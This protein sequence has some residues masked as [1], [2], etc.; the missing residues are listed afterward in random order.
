M[1]ERTLAVETVHGIFGRNSPPQ[2]C[3][4]PPWSQGELHIEGLSIRV[5]P[6]RICSLSRMVLSGIV[7]GAWGGLN[8]RPKALSAFQG[9]K[10]FQI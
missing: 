10:W 4:S 7:M 5:T 3:L 9:R 6:E 2:L 8:Q 1:C